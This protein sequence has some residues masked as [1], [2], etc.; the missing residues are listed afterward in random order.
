MTMLQIK[1]TTAKL[2]RS[3]IS[4]VLLTSISLSALAAPQEALGT[5]KHSAL[6]AIAQAV[7]QN[8]SAA[9]ALEQLNSAKKSAAEVVEKVNT[10]KE[11][12]AQV[13]EKVNTAKES[14]AQVAEKVS[15]TKESTSTEQ[16]TTVKETVESAKDSG[17]GSAT[18]LTTGAMN[19]APKAV[20]SLAASSAKDK[21]TLNLCNI[22]TI[23]SVFKVYEKEKDKEHIKSIQR[24]LN[25][26]GYK[27][28]VIDGLTGTDT[29]NAFK[30]LCED[31]QVNKVKDSEVKD[32][33]AKEP[34][35]TT[36]NLAKHLVK[37]LH[38]PAP[39][40]L[41]GGDCGCTGDESTMVY[42]FYPYLLA[43]GKPQMLDF[44]LFDRI[45]FQGLVLDKDGDIPHLLQWN[46]EADAGKHAANFINEAHKYRVKVDMTFYAT[47]WQ[48]W[49]EKTSDRAIKNMVKTATQE[50]NSNDGNSLGW[51][52]LVENTSIARVDG[53]NVHFDNFTQSA[54]SQRLI[55]IVQSLAESLKDKALALNLNIIL[56]GW[57]NITK[58]QFTQLKEIL[59]DDEDTV[60][61]VFLFL[62]TDTSSESKKQLRQIIEN[63]FSGAERKKVLR[64]IVPIIDTR[65]GKLTAPQLAQFNDD[66][67]YL[68]DNFA[69]A[70]LLPLPLKSMDSGDAIGKGLFELDNKVNNS[71]GAQFEQGTASLCQF[72]CPNRWLFYVAI[73]VI[74]LIMGI[75]M[76]ATWS[77][78]LRHMGQWRMLPVVAL[79]FLAAFIYILTLA[80][81]PAWKGRIDI[82][83]LGFVLVFI[84]SI[85]FRYLR[86][87]QQ[88][89]LP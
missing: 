10:A 7:A 37:L 21:D 58:E 39:I 6:A 12:A 45:G 88:P 42:G 23:D 20:S 68:Q 70:G 14:A 19:A 29:D 49:T 80:C 77:C 55:D 38:E 8:K 79:A 75:F 24:L 81:D 53:I 16:V 47:E 86:K 5:K 71:T 15:T 31:F 17:S 84:A 44:S 34:V 1:I 64:K 60:D 36:K 63:T 56:G 72:V 32:N 57:P 74:V 18:E 76:L 2:T 52:P 26:G 59:V 65:D 50:F 9:A 46:K 62:P 54:N 30:A 11:S 67:I 25:L 40:V 61:N 28:G 3:L 89:P 51:L 87:I 82:V 4:C 69:G 85:L 83:V 27:P 33:E 66:L 73:D 78:R 41:S 22:T 35:V 43:Q 48:S 13:V